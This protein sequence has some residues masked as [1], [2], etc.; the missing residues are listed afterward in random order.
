MAEVSKGRGRGDGLRRSGGRGGG[1]GGADSDADSVHSSA[2]PNKANRLCIKN[3]WGKCPD[4]EDKCER[5]LHKIPDSIPAGLRKHGLF[6]KM[7]K[8]FGEPDLKS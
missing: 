5:G 2:L 3:L 6:E 7:L 4:P 1:G 8:E